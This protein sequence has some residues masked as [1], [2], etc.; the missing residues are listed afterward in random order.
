MDEEQLKAAEK[1]L[2]ARVAKLE[3]DID[4][5][6]KEAEAE[7]TKA[8]AIAAGGAAPEAPRTSTRSGSSF[9]AKTLAAFGK[10][11]VKDLLDLNVHSKRFGHVDPAHKAA[12]ITL[13][14]NMDVARF[15]A[16]IFYDAPLDK[17][18]REEK[19]DRAAAV[20]NV[21]DTPFGR[22]VA[23][24]L[25]AFGTHTAGAGSEWI[26]TALSAQFIEDFQ[27]DRQV[28]AA[29]R[30][31]P[32]PT[33]PYKLTVQKNTTVARIAKEGVGMTGRNFGTANLTFDA[34]KLGEFYPLSEELNEDSAPA[35]LALARQEVGTA[36]IRAR[37]TI[38]LNGDTTATHMDNDVTD[39]DDARRLAKGLRK[40]GLANTANGGTVTFSSGVTTAKLDEMRTNMGKFGVSVSDLLY[41]LGP[42]TY[43]QAV[44]LTEVS[45]VDKFGAL[46]TMLNGALAAFRGIPLMISE[47]VREDVA[48]SG[49][50]TS[51]G[52]NTKGVVYLVHKGR[53]WVGLRRPIR[54][55]VMQDSVDQDR[56]LMGSYS[57]IDFQGM[58]QSANE[59][60]VV[61]GIDVTV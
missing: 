54:V 18:G 42:T 38:I 20:K 1:A 58:A 55:R 28:A 31:M 14:E 21:L 56:W 50:N 32:M 11:H 9:E 45:T 33:N 39:S 4:K 27:L 29:F 61:V 47:Y 46:A 8:A 36:Q 13:K 3:A 30:E 35:I 59:T 37:E 2:E 22:E 48:A 52:P 57:R 17:G 12:V 19:A 51:G 7:K 60:S 6:S 53:F 23:A 24:Q 43:N 25:K 16:Q 34:T 26:P 49:V 5:Q 44:G 40:L 41:I 10:T 15:I